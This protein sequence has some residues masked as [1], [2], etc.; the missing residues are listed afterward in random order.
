MS[1]FQISRYENA[2]IT[3][4][5][6]AMFKAE[7]QSRLDAYAGLV[8][9]D[10]TIVSAKND[11]ATLNKV[12]KVIEDARKT[13]K[14]RCLAPYEALEPQIKELVEMVEKQRTL[15]DETV[16]DYETRQR[17]TKEIE[18]RQ[19]YNRKAVV[20]GTYADILYPK[21]FDKRW[22]NVSTSRAKCEESILIAINGAV[23]DMEAISASGSPFVETLL[24]IYAETLSMEQVKAKQN[25][26]E[27]AAK[28]AS[29]TTTGTGKTENMI[30]AEE[31]VQ[32]DTLPVKADCEAGTDVKIYATENQWKQLSD[33]MKAIGV[34]YELL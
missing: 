1:E 11:R 3:T 15:I 16:K 31:S 10:E 14:A 13:Y 6:F 27:T 2:D 20:L 32:A 7:L 22:L 24:D 30:A 19:Y 5:D 28:K 25:E 21:L 34:R 4:W 9:T 33:F 8:Y 18:V 26:L 17:E 29:L 12:K 23:T